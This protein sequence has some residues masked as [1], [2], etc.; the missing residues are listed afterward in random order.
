M[1]ANCVTLYRWRAWPE[2]VQNLNAVI[3]LLIFLKVFKYLAVIP[4]MDVLFA[5]LR[6]AGL[7]LLLFSILFLIVILGCARLRPIARLIASDCV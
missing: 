1:A 2:Q 6:V 5:T 4:Q 3:A 7:E